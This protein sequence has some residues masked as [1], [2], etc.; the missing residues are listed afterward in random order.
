MI[1]FVYFDVGGVVMKDFSGTKKWEE[2]K[3]SI[4]VTPEQDERFDD[5]YDQAEIEVCSGKDAETLIPIMESQFGLSFP[6][7]YSFLADFV[8]R[9]ER[10][11]SIWPVLQEARKKYNIG[12]LTNMYPRMLDMIYARHLMPDIQ[13]DTVI[14]SS[15][16]KMQKPQ[17]EIFQLAEERCGFRGQEILF[18]ENTKRHV[19]AAHNFGWRTFLYDSRNPAES[20]QRLEEMLLRKY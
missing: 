17:V 8:N 3:R 11:E 7:N 12:L 2:L 20:N 19:E 4:G 18:I 15:I 5:F 6:Q 14:D 13:W 16:E 9:F 10:N 1:R